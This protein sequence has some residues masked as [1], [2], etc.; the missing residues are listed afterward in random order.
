MEAYIFKFYESD[1][2]ILQLKA[3]VK[4]GVKIKPAAKIF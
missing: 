4:D 1:V 2:H 3:E